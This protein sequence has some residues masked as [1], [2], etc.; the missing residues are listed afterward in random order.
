MYHRLFLI[1]KAN[2]EK[3]VSGFD[4]LKSDQQVVILKH[5]LKLK[6]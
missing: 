3:K 6:T 1:I 5:K 2:F 4:V